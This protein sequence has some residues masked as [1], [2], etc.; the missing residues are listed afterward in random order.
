MHKDLRVM[1]LDKFNH[2]WSL[3][4]DKRNI[5]TMVLVGVV[6]VISCFAFSAKNV[7]LIVEEKPLQLVVWG[8]SVQDVL[9]KAGVQLEKGDIVRPAKDSKIYD[10]SII[11]TAQE[12]KIEIVDGTEKK[13]ASM[14][15]PSVSEILASQGI[16]LGRDDVVEA[17]LQPE[18]DKEPFI[19]ITRR[20]INT[21][22]E[23]E[24]VAYSVKQETD[25]DL[26][27]WES[28]M[29]R[30]GVNGI[31]EKTVRVV[32][33][34]GKEVERKIVNSET[35]REPVTEIVLHSATNL[36]RGNKI[37]RSVQELSM[38]AT[39]YTHTGNRTATGTWPSRGTV[40]VDPR[41]IPLGTPLYVEGYGFAVAEDTG[42]A[43]KGNKVDVFLENRKN[44][45][46]WGKKTVKVQILRK[47]N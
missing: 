32:T 28:K 4:K 40:A 8:R 31:L 9:N 21:F 24:V 3:I 2:N 35:I 20:D 19:N 23:R 36:S 14:T 15:M 41:T 44:A 7:T 25:A 18:H 11:V 12:K 33:E 13:V 16:T 27:P 10:G 39:A 42:G 47:V 17:Q 38:V 46:K 45:V 26:R 37:Y 6:L 29:V 34:N 43:I 1:G 5:A 30:K 22:K